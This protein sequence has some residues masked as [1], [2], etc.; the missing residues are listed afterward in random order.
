MKS[1]TVGGGP[2]SF[3]LFLHV[4]KTLNALALT[5]PVFVRRKTASMRDG[6]GTVDTS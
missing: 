6:L 3:S 1:V 2:S 4:H 5:I